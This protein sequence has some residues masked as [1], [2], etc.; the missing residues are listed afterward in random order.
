[1]RAFAVAGPSQPIVQQLVAQL[2]WGQNLVLLERLDEPA[3]RIWYAE[4]VIAHGWSRSI[5]AINIQRPLHKRAGRAVNNFK[6]TLPPPDSDLAAQVFKDPYLFDFLGTADPRHVKLPR[7]GG[8]PKTG[9]SDAE[10][11]TTTAVLT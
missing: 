1:M 5:L 4:Q 10:K 3:T 6:A 8:H 7:F 11:A 2:P 9:V